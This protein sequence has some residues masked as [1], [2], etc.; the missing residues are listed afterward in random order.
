MDD[1]AL[2]QLIS[3]INE[4]SRKQRSVGLDKYEKAE[5]DLLRQDYLSYIRGQVIHVLEQVKEKDKHEH[6]H[7]CNH[8]HHSDQKH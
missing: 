4:L 7:R 1:I 3:R 6:E 2:N 8:K 5:Q